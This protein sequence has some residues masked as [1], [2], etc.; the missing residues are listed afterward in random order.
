VDGFDRNAWTASAGIGGRDQ[1][2]Y[3]LSD[4]IPLQLELLETYERQI[5]TVESAMV[6]ALARAPEA[7]ALL[8]PP[9]EN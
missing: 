1:P 3:A 6:E 4:E 8:S 7:E 5:A 9:V 2:E